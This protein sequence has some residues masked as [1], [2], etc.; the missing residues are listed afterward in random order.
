MRL[1]PERV[2]PKC[3][4]DRSL[5]IAHGLEDVFWV[6]DR[7][8]QVEITADPHPPGSQLVRERKSP[9]VKAA[10]EDLLDAGRPAAAARSGARKPKS[11]PGE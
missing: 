4:E 6:E 9:A 11:K 7:G 1:W 2:V 3:A 8:G 10:L 5:A